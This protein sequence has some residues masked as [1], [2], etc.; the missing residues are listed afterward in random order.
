MVFLKSLSAI[1]LYLSPKL[2]PCNLLHLSGGEIFLTRTFG[3]GTINFLFFTLLQIK[4]DQ[5]FFGI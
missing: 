1:E 2:M 4:S 3:E 5:D